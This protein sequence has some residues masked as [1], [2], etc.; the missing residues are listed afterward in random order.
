MEIFLSISLLVMLSIF[1]RAFDHF[2][3]LF[4]KMSIQTILLRENYKRILWIQV[5]SSCIVDI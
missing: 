4:G 5:F 1:S 3:V 2:Y